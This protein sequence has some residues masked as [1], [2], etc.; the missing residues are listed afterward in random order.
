MTSYHGGK[1][2]IGQDLAKV[3]YNTATNIENKST[4][5]IKG[6]CEPFCGML[7]VYRHIPELFKDHK[8]ELKYLAGDSNESVIKMWK[9]AQKGWKPPTSCSKKRYDELKR[10]KNR[11]SAEKGFI[12]H[13]YS[14][15]GQFFQGYKGLYG[16]S[17]TSDYTSKNVSKIAGHLA[18]VKFTYGQYTEFSH[19]RN[20]IIYCD[21]PY[22]N[23]RCHYQSE[24]D[25]HTFWKWCEKMSHNN[26]IFVSGYKVVPKTSLLY[27]TSDSIRGIITTNRKRV[28]YLLLVK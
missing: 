24:F 16:G 8:P 7:G 17:K 4:F 27:S 21:P 15:G 13:Q 22:N 26:L 11:S 6:Y 20:Y 10:T 14:F 12:G 3:I 1:Q 23:T 9:K 2:R 5:K 28:E 19:L 25:N 18:E